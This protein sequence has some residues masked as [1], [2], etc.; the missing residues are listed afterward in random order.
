MVIASAGLVGCSSVSGTSSNDGVYINSDSG[1]KLILIDGETVVS[2]TNLNSGD[3]CRYYIT[4][5]E[6]AEK[7][8]LDA[9]YVNAYE[10]DVVTG[11]VN[12]EQSIVVWGGDE[13]QPFAFDTPL[14]GSVTT[15]E[16]D[17]PSGQKNIIFVPVDSDQAKPIIAERRAKTC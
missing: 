17:A 2:A 10:G 6:R 8:E 14:E 9:D 13:V 7:G 5:L 16:P 4:M 15:D 12:R 11:V 1:T 3:A